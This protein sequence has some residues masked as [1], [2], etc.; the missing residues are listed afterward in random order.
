MEQLSWLKRYI[1]NRELEDNFYHD[2]D[3]NDLDPR[4][5][6]NDV[7]F[8]SDKNNN[9]SIFD[10]HMSY[11]PK[12][13]QN[14]EQNSTRAELYHLQNL[15]NLKNLEEHGSEH[16]HQYGVFRLVDIDLNCNYDM[17]IFTG[18]MFATLIILTLVSLKWQLY[19]KKVN[20]KDDNHK[21]N[22]DLTHVVIH[23]KKQGIW[24]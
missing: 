1:Y 22:Q 17:L 23:P 13:E 10:K 12:K 5:D 15:E 18:V 3:E 2:V 20:E 24:F 16:S 6:I 19:W 8:E 4:I 14:P 9:S 11:E 7:F 21:R